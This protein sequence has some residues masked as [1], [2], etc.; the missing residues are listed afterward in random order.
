[1]ETPTER[2]KEVVLSYYKDLKG[3]SPDSDYLFDKAINKAGTCCLEM[4]KRHMIINS[5]WNRMK[6]NYWKD[7]KSKCYSVIND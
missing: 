3:N 1:M 4:I 5:E 7:V 6:V 2:A